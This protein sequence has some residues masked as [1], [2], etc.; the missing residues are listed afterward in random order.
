MLKYQSFE[1]K[2]KLKLLY[3]GHNKLECDR[4]ESQN[5]MKPYNL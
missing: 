1:H 2:L 4:I 3:V 5:Y